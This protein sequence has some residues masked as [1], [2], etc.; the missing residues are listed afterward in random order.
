MKGRLDSPRPRWASLAAMALVVGIL[1]SLATPPRA[2]AASGGARLWVKR[3]NGPG[4]GDDAACC[5]TPSPD[6]STVFVTGYSLGSTGSKDY[7]TVANDAS[8][9]A[10]L[11]VDRYNGPGPLQRASGRGGRR[12]FHH[13]EPKWIRGVRDGTQSGHEFLLLRH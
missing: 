4:N 13:G 9:G 10:T 7:T 8:T 6:G 1:S 2:A 12:H 3:Y 11:W 5:V